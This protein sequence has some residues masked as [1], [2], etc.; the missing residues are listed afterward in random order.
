MSVV[1][2]AARAWH[3]LAYPWDAMARPVRNHMPQWVVRWN[4]WMN[5]HFP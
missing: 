1:E 5:N 2:R 4:D 3:L